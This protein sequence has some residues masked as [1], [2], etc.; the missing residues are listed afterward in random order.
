MSKTTGTLT[1]AKG[2]YIGDICYVLNDEIYYGIWGAA[3]FEDGIYQVPERGCRFAVAG[4]AYGDGEFEDTQLR[5][6]G[7]DAG[8][9]G[10][11]PAELIDKETRGG[12]YFEGP[13]RA[14]FSAEGG[15]FEIT[16]PIG[17]TI[18]IDTHDHWE[19]EDDYYEEEDWEE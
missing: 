17:E 15:C 16:L 4:T 5:Q 6:Y 18:Y 11:V 13:G 12:H 7:V 9:I 19:D 8:V 2:F 10:L 14:V 3:G 1:S